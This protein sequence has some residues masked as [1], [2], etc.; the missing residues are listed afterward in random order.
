VGGV[1]SDADLTTQLRQTMMVLPIFRGL[2]PTIEESNPLSR[3]EIRHYVD[4]YKQVIRPVLKDS[5]VYHHTPVAPM[6]EG[7]PWTVLEYATPDARQSLGWIFR[8]SEQGNSI[9]RF[10]PCGRISPRT[11]K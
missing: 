9:Y 7:S 6:L 8:T 3:N 4:L 2:S 11:M 1:D 5:R 10:V